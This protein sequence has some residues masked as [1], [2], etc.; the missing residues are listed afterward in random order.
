LKYIDTS[1]IIAALDPSDPRREKLVKFLEQEKDKVISELVLLE[2]A[3]V[4]CRRQDVL[5]S[6]TK[7]LRLRNEQMV[8]AIILYIIKRF[9]LRYVRTDNQTIMPI[10]GSIYSPIAIA[11]TISKNVRLRALDLLHVAYVKLLKSKGVTLNELVTVDEDFEKAREY[12]K[13][14]LNVDVLILG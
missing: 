6:I 14:E 4:I 10:I 12:L 9:K 2:L 8:L 5:A 1:V 3:S 13:K 11:I 7:K